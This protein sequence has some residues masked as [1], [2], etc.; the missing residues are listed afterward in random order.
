MSIP[1]LTVALSFGLSHSL[2]LFSAIVLLHECLPSY[3]S[4]LDTSLCSLPVHEC[5]SLEYNSVE[6]N[7]NY[8]PWNCS[9]AVQ[10]LQLDIYHAYVGFSTLNTCD[11]IHKQHSFIGFKPCSWYHPYLTFCNLLFKHHHSS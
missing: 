10:N 5:L 11:Y 6:Y 2:V 1:H 7:V 3:R 8:A 9:A 4:P